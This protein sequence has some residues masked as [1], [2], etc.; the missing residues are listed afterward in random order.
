MLYREVRSK[1]ALKFQPTQS[2][3][4]TAATRYKT[5]Q[6]HLAQ[7]PYRYKDEHGKTEFVHD[8]Q[9]LRKHGQQGNGC[10]QDEH[11]GV[12]RAVDGNVPPGYVHESLEIKCIHRK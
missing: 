2:T 5:I 1:F 11:A 6:T 8:K 7:K 10:N 12:E 3:F 9:I 4:R